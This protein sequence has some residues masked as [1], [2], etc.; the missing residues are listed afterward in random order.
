ML[1]FRSL[2][3][4]ILSLYFFFIYPT[5]SSNSQ[6][7]SAPPPDRFDESLSRD[8]KHKKKSK[9]KEKVCRNAGVFATFRIP[10]WSSSFVNLTIEVSLWCSGSWEE[11]CLSTLDW[12]VRL[13]YFRAQSS[14]SPLE[15][16]HGLLVDI[17]V[18]IEV[19]WPRT[20]S[21]V[22]FVVL[23]KFIIFYS[24]NKLEL[25]CVLLLAEI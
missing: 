9:K 13:I 25:F 10:S 4:R 11:A 24:S 19:F 5:A 17:S 18:E 7:M 12:R 20:N 15:F 14:R 3:W 22:R 23:C 6:A 1:G 16:S 2:F 8:K 21:F